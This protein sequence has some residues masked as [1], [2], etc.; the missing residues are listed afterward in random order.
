M[1]L[2][3]DATIEFH[4]KLQIWNQIQLEI[5]FPPK[6]LVILAMSMS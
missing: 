1:A 2:V 4:Y 6:L 5:I 3:I